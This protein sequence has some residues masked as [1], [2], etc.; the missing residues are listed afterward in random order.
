MQ[1][2][3]AKISAPSFRRRGLIRSGPHD[4]ETFKFLSTSLTSWVEMLMNWKE[5][6]EV[7][8]VVEA[9]CHPQQMFAK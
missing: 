8:V 3:L 9:Y 4:F 5:C 1:R 6:W 2:G 7:Q